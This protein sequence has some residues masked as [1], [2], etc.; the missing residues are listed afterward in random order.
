MKLQLALDIFSLEEALA[1]TEKVKDYVDIIEIGTPFVVESGM[2]AVR[3]FRQ[4]FPDKEILSDTKIMD[5]AE[6]EAA[7]AFEAGADYVTVLA[8]TDR[9]TLEC[10]VQIADKYGKKIVADMICVKDIPA[11]VAELEE[12]GVHCIAVHT[13]VDAQKLGKTPLEDLKLIKKYSKKA[14][15]FV[16]GGISEKTIPEYK[17]QNPDV[18][19]IGGGIGSAADPVKAA[20][21]MAELIHY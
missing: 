3:R 17:A 20:A 15:V 4:A 19:I 10:A 7:S 8:V 18:M 6:L 12:I 13:G 16:A 14:E 11:K 2:E 9:I 1:L 21:A 5:A